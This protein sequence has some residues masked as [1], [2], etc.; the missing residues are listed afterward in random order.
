MLDQLSSPKV[1][2]FP[3]L[4]AAIPGS[5]KFRLVTNASADGLGV[6]IEQQQPDSEAFLGWTAPRSSRPLGVTENCSTQ[7]PSKLRQITNRF[8]IFNFV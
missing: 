7:S 8:K 5:R 1:L 4:E 2:A 6:V 3:D